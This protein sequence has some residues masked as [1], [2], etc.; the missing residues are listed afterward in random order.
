MTANITTAGLMMGNDEILIRQKTRVPNK[1]S[2]TVLGP[3]DGKSNPQ[4]AFINERNGFLPEPFEDWQITFMTESMAR[5]SKE[6]MI[7]LEVIQL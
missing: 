4:V 1:M 7:V 2:L 5:L 3:E 6:F